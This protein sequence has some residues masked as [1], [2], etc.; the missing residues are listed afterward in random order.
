M[1]IV[2]CWHKFFDKFDNSSGWDYKFIRILIEPAI[3]VE[4]CRNYYLN[5]FKADDIVSI[6]NT[7]NRDPNGKLL[8]ELQL[9]LVVWLSFKMTIFHQPNG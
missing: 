5:M 2:F 1:R 4:S 7:I 3:K 6:C 9:T 8:M